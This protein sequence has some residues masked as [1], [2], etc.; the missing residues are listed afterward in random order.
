MIVALVVLVLRLGS[1]HVRTAAVPV[2]SLPENVVLEA[3]NLLRDLVSAALRNSPVSFC[4][5]RTGMVRLHPVGGVV[6]CPLPAIQRQRDLSLHRPHQRHPV[7]ADVAGASPGAAGGRA[8]FPGQPPAARRGCVRV[9]PAET[10]PLPEPS[11]PPGAGRRL[12]VRRGP[13]G[14]SSVVLLWQRDLS[15]SAA[16]QRHLRV[17]AAAARCALGPQYCSSPTPQ[18]LQ[19]MTSHAPET[20]HLFIYLSDSSCRS[21]Y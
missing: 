19:M 15:S 8:S 12:F 1:V 9:G 20:F 14:S 11:E 6:S 16:G 21:A 5:I 17:V 10:G 13:L 4:G 7:S 18:L 2:C 3:H